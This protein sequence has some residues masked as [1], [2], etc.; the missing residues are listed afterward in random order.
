MVPG[1]RQVR[2]A[3]DLLHRL[4]IDFGVKRR[5]HPTCIRHVKGHVEF[6][7]TYISHRVE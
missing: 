6:I 4:E 3:T 2:K 1:E 7:W 5:M